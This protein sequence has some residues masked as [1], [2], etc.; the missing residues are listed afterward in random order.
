MRN[1]M[2]ASIETC[3]NVSNNTTGCNWQKSGNSCC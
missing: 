1:H 2:F 3:F